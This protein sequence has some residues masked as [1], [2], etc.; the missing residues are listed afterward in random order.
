M[1]VPNQDRDIPTRRLVWSHRGYVDHS[2]RET[3]PQFVKGPIPMHWLNIAAALPGKSLHIG[4]WLWYLAGVA[5]SKEVVVSNYRLAPWGISRHQ[6]ARGL[7]A[8]ERAGLVKV[9]RGA[10]R[11][12]RVLILEAPLHD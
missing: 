11:N 7:S 6:K 10:G 8:L 9:K 12:P 3:R 2:E 4:I 1:Y 5:R